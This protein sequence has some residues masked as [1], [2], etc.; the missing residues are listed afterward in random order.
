MCRQLIGPDQDSLPVL[1][2]LCSPPRVAPCG[3]GRGGFFIIII[4]P[5][6]STVPSCVQA[7]THTSPPFIEKGI[8]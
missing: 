7:V 1:D 5:R 8:R 4:I 3:L 6:G 2:I